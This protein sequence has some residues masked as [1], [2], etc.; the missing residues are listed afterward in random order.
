MMEVNLVKFISE[1]FILS[2]LIQAPFAFGADEN[3]GNPVAVSPA[4]CAAELDANVLADL[5]QHFFDTFDPVNPKTRSISGKI[6]GIEISGGRFLVFLDGPKPSQM[7][8]EIFSVLGIGAVAVEYISTEPGQLRDTLF[9]RTPE[10]YAEN[11]VSAD[12]VVNSPLHRAALKA[13]QAFQTNYGILPEVE[14]SEP[15]GAYFLVVR[16][17]KARERRGLPEG[18]FQNLN[19]SYVMGSRTP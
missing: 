10:S 1:V 2:L 12:I 14:Y 15:E 4:L 16:I 17:K 7:P 18:S 9:R 8:A 19:I 13:A 5:R 3:Q 11:A 6:T